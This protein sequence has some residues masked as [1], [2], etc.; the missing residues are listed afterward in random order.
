MKQRKN[1][2]VVFYALLILSVSF[3]A[4]NKKP[5]QVGL[6]LQPASSELSVLFDE[7]TGLFSH[8]LREDSVRTDVNAVQTASLGSM[9]DPVFGKTNAE[10]Y[11]QFR[12]SENGQNFG[13][14]P[15]FDSLIL[16]LQYSNFYGDSM[17]DQ[18]IRIYELA[19]DLDLD[20]TY[21]SNQTVA[22]LGIEV[23]ALTFVPNPSD[24]V[25][26]GGNMQPPQLRIQLTEEFALKILNAE[27][28]VFED[29]ESWLEFMK[30]LRI[31]AD[32]SAGDGGIMLFDMFSSLT[33][34]TMYYR[35]G[36]PQ[37]T[38]S[39]TF[40]SNN[41]C[42]RFTAFNHNDYL[43]ASADL[44]AQ[45]IDK[46]T[47]MGQKL[48]YLQAMGG[49]KA[50]IRLPDLQEFFADDPVAINEAKLI[51]NVYDDGSNLE[52]PPQLALAKIDEE[53]NYV[54]LPDA[55]ESLSYYGGALNDAKT[56]YFFRISRHV[57]QVLTGSSPNS[58]LILLISGSS[59]RANRLIL[60]GPDEAFNAE[61]KMVLELIYTKVN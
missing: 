1:F 7:S 52:P 12:L 58:P 43:D 25:S 3:S 10:I 33:A 46:D 9:L 8:S 38:L 2:W 14:D 44:R 55:S 19:D 42:A 34:L 20:T 23:G 35:V 40:I 56:R 27:T 60:H 51:L 59:F 21:F 48:I 5:D 15:I 45:I 53:G 30:G 4:C 28:S 18:T 36:S 50:Q 49:V 6:G 29:N 13:T 47:A 17:S 16:S 24:S 61:N 41:N 11:S 31:T 37:D 39:F 22:D 26:V 57:Q 54:L 32:E